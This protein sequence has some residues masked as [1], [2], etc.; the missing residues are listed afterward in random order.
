MRTFSVA[1][2]AAQVAYV[3]QRRRWNWGVTLGQLPFI[4]G[5][6]LVQTDTTTAQGPVAITKRFCF[7]KSNTAPRGSRPILSTAPRVSNSAG[8]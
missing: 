6:V 5:G 8:P 1:D 4:S 7:V 3:D 2:V